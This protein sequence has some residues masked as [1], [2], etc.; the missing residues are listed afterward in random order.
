MA[1][2][3]GLATAMIDISDGL[4]SDLSRLCAASAVGCPTG[5]L[6]DF[7]WSDSQKLPSNSATTTTP[8]V[9]WRETITN[10][11]S[12]CHRAKQS[13]CRILFTAC[14]SLRL[15]E[16]PKNANCYCGMRPTK[17]SQL[18]PRGWDPFRK[19]GVDAG[20]TPKPDSKYRC[21]V[22][23]TTRTAL[24]L[25]ST[26]PSIRSLDQLLSSGSSITLLLDTTSRD[27]RPPRP[28]RLSK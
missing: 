24:G 1:G 3:E 4:S 14:A 21:S 22:W 9:A 12:P 11:C 23:Y 18:T 8:R 13:S 15:E 28:S 16:S 25:L 19:K 7:R 2:E 20:N 17:M 26:L 5:K 6:E 27:S 10:Y